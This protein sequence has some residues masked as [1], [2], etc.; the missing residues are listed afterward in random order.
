MTSQVGSVY[1]PDSEAENNAK[2]SLCKHCGKEVESMPTSVEA[3][4]WRHK[5]GYYN[6]DGRRGHSET[7]AEP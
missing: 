7:C 6:C 3:L 2:T 1:T 5:D 4:R